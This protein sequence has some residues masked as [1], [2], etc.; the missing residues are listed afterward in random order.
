MARSDSAS[1]DTRLLTIVT[2]VVTI[3][4]L[5]LAQE[6]LIPFALA[7]LFS[8][9]LAPLVYRLERVG[10]WRVPAV[11]LVALL[12]FTFLIGLGYIL[13]HQLVEVTDRLPEYRE[14]I[15]DRIAGV[16][17][18][19]GGLF[20]RAGQ[21]I[22]V[23]SE[24]LAT[25]AATQPA[26]PQ[27]ALP[28][29]A[30]QP[31]P[32]RIVE[33]PQPPLEFVRTTLSTVLHPLL[34]A[35][36]VVIFTIFILV[37]REDLRDRMIRLAG[38]ERVEVTTKAFDDAAQRISRYLLML[39]TINLTF[40]LAVAL[41]LY[42]LGLP[43]ALLWGL[44]A[45]ALRFV[46]YIGIWIGMALPLSLSLAVWPHGWLG[47]LAVAA[48]VVG[49][50]VLAANV[51]EPLLYGHGAGISPLAV[52]VAAV[53][54]ASL[55]GPVGL[56][57]STPLTVCLVVMGKY[58]PALKF[59]EI[60]LTDEPVLD[61]PVR[62]YQR[63]LAGDKE[64]AQELAETYLEDASLVA[65]YDQVLIPALH[66]AE[67]DRHRGR[68][69]EARTETVFEGA[70]ETIDCLIARDTELGRERE[71]IR[72]PDKTAEQM[73]SPAGAARAE[74]PPAGA[75]QAIQVL[76][77]PAR[78]RADEIVA[79]MLAQVLSRSGT[80]AR[81]VP[82]DMLISEMLEAVEGSGARIVC[83]SGMPPGAMARVRHLCKRLEGRFPDT[84]V[85]VCLWDAAGDVTRARQRLVAGGADHVVTTV[86]E[87]L[88]IVR[89]SRATRRV[90]AERVT[91]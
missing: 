67:E 91:G 56:L 43:N 12:T 9:L 37:Q 88:H 13:S 69:D 10:V 62:F 73:T 3:A 65:V 36:L 83:I 45:G 23:I 74:R 15:R 48:V 71:Q 31:A 25:Q 42:L 7:V 21:N 18:S 11:L 90:P 82:A 64:E 35:G 39:A 33:S 52:L 16:R 28:E 68:L 2:L 26:A 4:G 70:A 58:V 85:V 60:L 6:V 76:C 55:W 19:A 41:G 27:P 29:L 72:D 8:F 81:S 17:Q 5:Y 24:E 84:K 57:L 34:T 47:P 44:L 86:N 87:V 32:V 77:L 40:G 1:A 53:F 66:Q 63:L 50:E 51:A 30:E 89:P 61:P 46:P 79:M 78:A 59:L 49:L 38:E 22:Q 80:Q 54:W 14:A 20:G 75:P